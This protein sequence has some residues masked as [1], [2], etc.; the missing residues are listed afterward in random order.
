MEIGNMTQQ[1]MM[2]HLG[3]DQEKGGWINLKRFADFKSKEVALLHH[4][5]MVK[6]L[7]IDQ[8]SSSSNLKEML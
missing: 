7:I 3:L 5:I 8:P 6:P 1:W 2:F 4:A